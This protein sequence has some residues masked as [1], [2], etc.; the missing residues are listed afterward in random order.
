MP[1]RF[2]LMN[3]IL[4]DAPAQW[5][6]RATSSLPVPVSLVIN[7]VLRVATTSSIRRITAS[8]PDGHRPPHATQ[9]SRRPPFPPASSFLI[10]YFLTVP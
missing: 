8:R 2:T 10:S 6:A 4:A 1:R 5:T 3:G 9:V 7:T